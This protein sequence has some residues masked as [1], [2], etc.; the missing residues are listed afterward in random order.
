M[1]SVMIPSAPR[2]SRRLISARSLMVHTCTSRPRAWARR[3]ND[4]EATL[5]G[6]WAQR[7]CQCASLRASRP[8]C[9]RSR[10]RRRSCR[11]GGDHGRRGRHAHRPVEQPARGPQPAAGERGHA[12]P[13]PGPGAAQHLG[14]Q[15]DA[16]LVL[17]VDVE[18]RVRPGAEQVLDQRYRLRARHPQR[19]DLA[20]GPR[21]DRPRP[22]GHPIEGAVVER[23]ELPVRGRAGVGLQV[24][25]AELDGVL[26]RRPG[27]LRRVRRAATVR[28]RVR[29]RVIEERYRHDR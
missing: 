4:A 20:V 19:A 9:R 25:V 5:A 21:A 12:H 10:V 2:S 16:R 27:V 26:E 15:R 3:T 22:V 7:T 18:A 6:T 11:D 28:E 23:H 17:E 8:G 14:Q 13:V 29:A 1:S 24:G